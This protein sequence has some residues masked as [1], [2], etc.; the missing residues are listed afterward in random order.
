MKKLPFLFF[1]ITLVFLSCSE[2]PY[3][4]SPRTYTTS[5]PLPENPIS[6]N[7]NWINGKAVGLDWHNVVTT[8]GLATGTDSPEA[9]SDPTALLTGAWGADQTVEAT[10]YSVNQTE[11]YYQEVELRLRSYISA[12]SNT[13]YEI[14]FRCLKNS[15]AIMA[16]VRWNGVLANFTYLSVKYGSQYGVAIGDVVKASIIGSEIKVYINDVLVDSVTDSTYSTGN[17]G[18]GFNYGC[19]LTYGDFGF[20]KFTASELPSSIR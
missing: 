9:Y 8:L 7:G 13:G 3:E 18:M 10:V 11:I 12:H 4:P 2:S 15:N 16:V 5:F 20:T 17:P 19:G 1:V 6:E 14:L